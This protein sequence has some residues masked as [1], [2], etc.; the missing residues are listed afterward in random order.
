M[1]ER[2]PIRLAG[3]P[4]RI[5]SRAYQDFSIIDR[6]RWNQGVGRSGA[7]S[8]DNNTIRD[9]RSFC[10]RQRFGRFTWLINGFSFLDPVYQ[11]NSRRTRSRLV[12]ESL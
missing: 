6:H 5:F 4:T 2:R 3:W 9:V 7:P 11:A 10:L 1:P 12:G 8:A